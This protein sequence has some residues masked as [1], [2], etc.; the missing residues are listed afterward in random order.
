MPVMEHTL[1]FYVTHVSKSLAYGIIK[2]YGQSCH[3]PKRLHFTITDCYCF[4]SFLQSSNLCEQDR[5]M[6]WSITVA[7]LGQLHSAEFTAYTIHRFDPTT[8]LLM[9]NI[10]ISPI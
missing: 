3:R 4:L 9:T 10:T 2:S 6:L 8:T 5:K 1:L 7:F